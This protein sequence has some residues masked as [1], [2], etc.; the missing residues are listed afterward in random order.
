MTVRTA[1][2][3]VAEETAIALAITSSPT[4]ERANDLF[5]SFITYLGRQKLRELFFKNDVHY[6]ILKATGMV[7]QLL[8]DMHGKLTLLN[9]SPTNY[10]GAEAA[11]KKVIVRGPDDAAEAASCSRRQIYHL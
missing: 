1:S 6:G 3:L 7:A 11:V 8:E 2:A 10:F 4:N 5:G 9:V